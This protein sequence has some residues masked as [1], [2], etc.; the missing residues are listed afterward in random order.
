MKNSTPI[1]P[2]VAIAGRG[3]DGKNRKERHFYEPVA[4]N[5]LGKSIHIELDAKTY[6]GL[7]KIC[8]RENKNRSAVLRPLLAEFVARELDKSS[9]SCHTPNSPIESGR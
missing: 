6:N 1:W 7:T 9:L 3:K 5:G 8:R 4:N 2:S